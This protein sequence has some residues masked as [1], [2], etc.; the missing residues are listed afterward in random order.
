MSSTNSVERKDTELATLGFIA[1]VASPTF[2]LQGIVPLPALL[3]LKEGDEK[4]GDGSNYRN[5]TKW[6][7]D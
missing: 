7:L 1:T 5:L 4:D 6:Y 3:R 2:R